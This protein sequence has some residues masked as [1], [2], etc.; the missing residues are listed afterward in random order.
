MAKTSITTKKVQKKQA[1]KV[2]S[3]VKPATKKVPTKK[4]TT[5]KKI[6]NFSAGPGV[7]P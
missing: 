4:T 1:K 7:L 2:I 3:K 6:Y 5:P